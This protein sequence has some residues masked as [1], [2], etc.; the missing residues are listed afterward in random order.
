M[1][2]WRNEPWRQGQLL[3]HEKAVEL[4]L[5]SGA[6]AVHCAVVLISHDCDIAAKTELEPNIE[7]IVGRY[8][9]VIDGD[10]ANAKNVRK[11]QLKY[12]SHRTNLLRWK[13]KTAASSPK[14]GSVV[15]SQ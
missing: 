7:V 3:T 11:L 10:F 15:V 2:E 8:V 6:D 13:R 12:G 14:H 4:D 5:T 1:A 9:N